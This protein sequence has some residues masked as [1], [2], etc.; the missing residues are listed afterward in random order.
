MTTRRAQKL[1]ITKYALE[2][3][4]LDN[5]TIEKLTTTLKY[6][7]ISTI[8]T[9]TREDLEPSS[10]K[11]IL[12]EGRLDYSYASSPGV[13]HT[14]I[15]TRPYLLHWKHGRASLLRKSLINM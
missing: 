11:D 10:R 6:S 1:E 14:R 2:I 3:I 5:E 12:R 9:I 7:S 13:L 15:S 4:E 8:E